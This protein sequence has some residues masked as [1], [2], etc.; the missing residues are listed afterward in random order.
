MK[1]IKRKKGIS[2]KKKD[3]T[4]VLYHIFPEYEI[5]YNQIPPRTIQEWHHHKIIEETIYVLSGTIEFHWIDKGKK[6]FEVLYPGDIVRAEDT[7]HTFINSSDSD[8]TFIVVRLI[9]NGR[10]VREVIKNDKYLDAV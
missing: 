2:V 9:L 1:I 7:T 10:D 8:V 4:I 6:T 3:G 5:H